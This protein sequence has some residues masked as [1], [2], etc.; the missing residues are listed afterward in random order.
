VSF[1]EIFFGGT[2]TAD[3]DEIELSDDE[4]DET[5]VARLRRAMV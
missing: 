2:A 3:W 4:D 1:F 5:E